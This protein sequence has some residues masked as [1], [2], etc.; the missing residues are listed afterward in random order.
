[1]PKPTNQREIRRSKDFRI[2]RLLTL[3]CGSLILAACSDTD[4]A[5]ERAQSFEVRGYVESIEP[6]SSRLMID[7]E[8]MPGYMPAMI[9]QFKVGDWDEARDLSPGDQ[10]RFEYHVASD[11][12]WIENIE[13]TGLARG[14][15]E[16]VAYSIDR[17]TSSATSQLQ[18]NA[19]LP[20]YSFIDENGRPVRLGDYRGSVVAM[21]FI[22]TRCPVPEYCPAMMRG[23]GNVDAMLK[24]QPPQ[25]APWQLVTISFDPENDTPEAMKRYGE[26]FDYD[27][28]NW[29]LLT[30]QS[31]EP[32]ESIAANVGLKFGKRDGSLLHN[33]RTVVLDPKGRITRIF[34]D[35]E[36]SPEE[37][38]AEM[39]RASEPR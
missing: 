9:M 17:Q 34:T 10:I 6:E 25:G 27:P 3:A 23:F 39:R 12:S 2:R 35:E 31:L 22:F 21:T 19:I 4:R 29:D 36:W 26:A 32:I 8:A 15:S 16:R 7:H 38:A 5:G 11:R 1:M 30:S 13:K 18:P 20:D 24:R 28:E 33:V 37:L 14:P